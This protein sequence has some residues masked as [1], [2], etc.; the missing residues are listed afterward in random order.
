MR[1]TA[2]RATSAGTPLALA[3]LRARAHIMLKN[4]GMLRCSL[5]ALEALP[6]PHLASL[7]H[8]HNTTPALP[9][10]AHALHPHTSP[11]LRQPAGNNG[12][13]PYTGDCSACYETKCTR[14]KVCPY[15]RRNRTVASYAAKLAKAQND[16]TLG[17]CDTGFGLPLG[18]RRPAAGST[19]C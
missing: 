2:T 15:D 1:E 3:S 5:K 11:R 19:K 16:K 4:H 12:T 10:P 17:T 14:A 18:A 9:A 8:M 7:Q 13:A 6:P